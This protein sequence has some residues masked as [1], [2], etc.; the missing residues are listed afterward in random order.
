LV[1][2]KALVQHAP[3]G[4]TLSASSF[5]SIGAEFTTLG[6]AEDM[7]VK[8]AHYSDVQNFG[9][10]LIGRLQDRYSTTINFT[11]KET[12]VFATQYGLPES[13]VFTA[14]SERIVLPVARIT[15]ITAVEA[16]SSADITLKAYPDI[17]GNV[18]IYQHRHSTWEQTWRDYCRAVL[19]G[20]GTQ[21]AALLAE[22]TSGKG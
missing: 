12:T 9:G 5:T 17:S 1:P 20:D 19:E 6:Y 10:A 7:T 21:A 3:V 11:T 15:R 4:S 18:I 16:F 14:P 8:Q 2:D 22:L 13:W